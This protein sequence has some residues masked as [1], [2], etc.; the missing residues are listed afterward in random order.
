VTVQFLAIHRRSRSSKLTDR[1]TILEFPEIWQLSFVTKGYSLDRLGL[2]SIAKYIY[3]NYLCPK[4]LIQESGIK[5]RGS[6]KLK[7]KNL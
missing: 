3:F 5:D 2:I 4:I 7:R 1:Q 6:A